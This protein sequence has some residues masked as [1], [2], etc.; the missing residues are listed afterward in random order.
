MSVFVCVC[1]CVC[2]CVWKKGE[3]GQTR[4][5]KVAR[6]EVGG[7]GG[8]GAEGPGPGWSGSGPA[9]TSWF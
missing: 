4:K 5:R 2:V 9:Y 3:R 7:K 6:R 8:R 1:V